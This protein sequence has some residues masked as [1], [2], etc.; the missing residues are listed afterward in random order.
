ML[1]KIL[2]VENARILNK[3]EQKQILGGADQAQYDKCR[4]YINTPGGGGYW[5]DYVT[6]EQASSEW[7]GTEYEGGYTASGYCCASCAS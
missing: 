4:L 3:K 7:D 2:I 5:S 1:K 6:Y